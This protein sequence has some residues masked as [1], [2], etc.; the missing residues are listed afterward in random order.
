VIVGS[1][2]EGEVF[3]WGYFKVWQL[4]ANLGQFE[5]R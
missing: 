5:R 4:D 2:G 3:P 1:R